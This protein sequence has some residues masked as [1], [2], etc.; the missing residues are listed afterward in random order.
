MAG[1][2]DSLDVA[3]DGAQ[4]LG[5]L[6]KALGYYVVGPSPEAH[7]AVVLWTA[8]THAQAAWQHATR[9]T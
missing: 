3:V 8:A 7:D 4:L 6:H 5:E 1:E 2:L 9:C